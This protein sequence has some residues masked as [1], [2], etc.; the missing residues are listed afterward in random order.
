[1]VE[2]IVAGTKGGSLLTQ[3]EVEG[4]KQYFLNSVNSRYTDIILSTPSLSAE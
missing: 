3:P 1:M 4:W 2:H